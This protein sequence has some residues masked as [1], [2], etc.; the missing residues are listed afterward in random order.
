M[1][2]VHRRVDEC[3]RF[4]AQM[5]LGRRSGVDADDARKYCDDA[6][7][8]VNERH[9]VDALDREPVARVHLFERRHVPRLAI[10]DAAN[11]RVHAWNV[12]GQLGGLAVH[13]GNRSTTVFA[14]HEERTADDGRG[15]R[16]SPERVTLAQR[17]AGGHDAVVDDVRVHRNVRVVVVIVHVRRVARFGEEGGGAIGLDARSHEAEWVARDGRVEYL[18]HL[19]HRCEKERVLASSSTS[20]CVRWALVCL[21][22]LA[23]MALSAS[24]SQKLVC[25]LT[26]SDGTSRSSLAWR[27]RASW[28]STPSGTQGASPRWLFDGEGDTVAPRLLWRRPITNRWSEY[29]APT[30][31]SCVRSVSQPSATSAHSP[32]HDGIAIETP[33]PEARIGGDSTGP[34][35]VGAAPRMPP[36]MCSCS[37]RGLVGDEK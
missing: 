12:D 6:A 4:V 34:L 8:R 7:L 24:S 13:E 5:R 23:W 9:V 28:S 14:R 25:I 22:T 16:V 35:R 30:I 33:M 18:G 21:Y 32:L 17:A 15:D 3:Q 2:L 1:S 37:W 36:A 27:S 20:C 19:G 10:D 31:A 11:E 29:I 26:V